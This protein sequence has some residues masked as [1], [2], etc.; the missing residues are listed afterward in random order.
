[1]ADIDGDYS[2]LPNRA[3]WLKRNWKILFSFSGILASG[4]TVV[5][6]SLQLDNSAPSILTFVASVMTVMLFIFGFYRE[7]DWNGFKYHCC[8]KNSPPIQQNGV[9]NFLAAEQ[10]PPRGHNDDVTE[11]MNSL[12]ARGYNP[13]V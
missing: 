4:L 7:V 5:L 11:A 6:L 13:D 2:I 9:V 1:M 10:D 3:E 8:N 12:A